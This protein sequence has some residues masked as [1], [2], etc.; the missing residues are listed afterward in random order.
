M[1]DRNYAAAFEV[2]Q[3][4]EA[5]FAAIVNARGWWS[6][7]IEG[8]S[9]ELGATFRYHFQDLHRCTIEVRELVPGRRVAWHVVDNYFSFIEDEAEW[10]GTDLVF[11]IARH[12]DKTNVKFTHVGLVPEYECYDACSDGWRTYITSSLRDLIVTGKGHPNA[13]DA[14]TGSE[15][16][17]TAPSPGNPMIKTGVH[18]MSDRSY[19]IAFTVDQTPEQVFAAINDVRAWWTGTLEGNTDKLGDEFTYRYEDAHRSTQRI[20]EFVPGKRVVWHVVDA[21]LSFVEDKAE[22]T[23]TD[24][25]FDIAR[26]GDKTEVRFTHVGLVPDV[27]CFTDCSNA[28]GYYV[29]GS[30]RNFIAAGTASAPTA[31]LEAV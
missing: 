5:A 31:T 9:D 7:A 29:N 22:W 2:D 11:D 15:K 25:V 23:G 26:N 18:V 6:E 3:S 28:W 21:H 27:E 8:K 10:T 30:L 24:I 13:G 20:T 4:P 1:T 12:G 16:S 14:I 17:L 19:T